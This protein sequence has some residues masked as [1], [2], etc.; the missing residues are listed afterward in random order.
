MQ[1]ILLQDVK[2]VGKKDA[3]VEVSD[4]Y[5][6]NYLIKNKLAVPASKKSMEVLGQQKEDARIVEENK[7][8]EA[9]NTAL[10]L[11]DITL[12]FALSVG[13][14]QRPFGSISFKQVEEELKNKHH[15]VIDK[16]KITSKD[17]LDSLGYHRLTIELYKGVFGEITVEIVER[18]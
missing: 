18:K 10:K 13:K 12:Q 6:R 9:Q 17:K 14:D 7:K 4:G 1:V 11:K 3:I 2:H 15:I 5:A 16:R 8:K